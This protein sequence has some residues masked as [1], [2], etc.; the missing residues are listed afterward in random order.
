LK[1][2]SVKRSELDTIDGIGQKKKKALLNHFKSIKAI[3]TASIEELCLVNGI[4]IKIAKK[5]YNLKY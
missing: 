3:K 4:S 2:K 5:V 1:N